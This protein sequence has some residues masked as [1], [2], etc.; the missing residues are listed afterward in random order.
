MLFQEA[1]SAAIM[2]IVELFLSGKCL[3][4]FFVGQL[5]FPIAEYG[6]YTQT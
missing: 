5:M 6:V 4:L 2:T 3:L 1:P